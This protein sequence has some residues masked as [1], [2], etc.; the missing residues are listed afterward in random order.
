MLLEQATFCPLLSE[1]AE[2]VECLDSIAVTLECMLDGD[3]IGAFMDDA[4]P[5]ALQKFASIIRKPP[6]GFER[7]KAIRRDAGAKLP[8]LLS[9]LGMWDEITD[10]SAPEDTDASEALDSSRT[11]EQPKPQLGAST[12]RGPTSVPTLAGQLY[13]T[14][15]Q[16]WPCRSDGHSPELHAGT[17]G[18]CIEADIQLDPRWVTRGNEERSFFV[19][20]RGAGISQECRVELSETAADGY[21]I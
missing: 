21:V 10:R 16:N 8:E 2:L 1:S 9:L 18:E 20:L 6:Y 11:R 3:Y 17:L 14:L 19:V 4:A 12:F 5:R 7:E 13:R 15:H